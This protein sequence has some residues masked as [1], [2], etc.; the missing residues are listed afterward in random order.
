MVIVPPHKV[1][2]VLQGWA[3]PGPVGMKCPSQSRNF[4]YTT[5]QPPMPPLFASPR[6]ISLGLISLL[7]RLNLV[8]PDNEGSSPLFFLAAESVF[9]LAYSNRTHIPPESIIISMRDFWMYQT[10]STKSTDLHSSPPYASLA[11]CKM[12]LLDSEG[13]LLEMPKICIRG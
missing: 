8:R 12:A 10:D 11:E 2:A 7:S 4:V 9:S 6:R 13:P 1:V 5:K 3:V